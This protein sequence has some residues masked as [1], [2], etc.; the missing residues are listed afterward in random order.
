MFDPRLSWHETVFLLTNSQLLA[1]YLNGLDVKAPTGHKSIMFPDNSD[2][3]DLS[4]YAEISACSPLPTNPSS[5]I[6]P[7]S[8]KNL[9]HRVH[10]IHVLNQWIL[11]VQYSYQKQHAFLRYILFYLP[12]KQRL[13][14]VNHILHLDHISD[15]QEGD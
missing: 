7:T 1:E 6:P 3:T 15:N 4:T 8:F 5:A 12:H 10:W 2:S 11:M 9:T 13:Y 14:P